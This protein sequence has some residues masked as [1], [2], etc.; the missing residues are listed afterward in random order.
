MQSGIYF[1]GPDQQLFRQNLRRRIYTQNQAS[2]TLKGVVCFV[3]F[4]APAIQT[5]L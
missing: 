4:V 2:A 3:T 1:N 5:V